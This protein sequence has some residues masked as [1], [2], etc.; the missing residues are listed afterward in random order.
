MARRFESDRG[1]AKGEQL[2]GDVTRA[3]GFRQQLVAMEPETQQRRAGQPE[4]RLPR[5]GAG[6]EA[7]AR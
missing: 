2:L 6:N 1:C 5:H 3:A 4:A 7:R